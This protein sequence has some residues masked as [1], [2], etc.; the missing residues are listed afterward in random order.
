MSSLVKYLLKHLLVISSIIMVYFLKSFSHFFNFIHFTSK[1]LSYILITFMIDNLCLYRTHLDSAI[2]SISVSSLKHFFLPAFTQAF[3]FFFLLYFPLLF[4]LPCF[5]FYMNIFF[6]FLN[7]CLPLFSSFTL[8]V[9]HTREITKFLKL[10]VVFISFKIMFLRCVHF[11]KND[12]NLSFYVINLNGLFSRFIYYQ[13]NCYK[14]QRKPC[15]LEP[16]IIEVIFLPVKE[17]DPFA[18]NTV[19]EY[20]WSCSVTSTLFY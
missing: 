18:K 13:L 2:F 5:S 20:S 12:S 19:A 10:N 9:S 3:F 7:S 8:Q 17:F 6:L 4:S 16:F 14:P 1:F 15:F 11:L